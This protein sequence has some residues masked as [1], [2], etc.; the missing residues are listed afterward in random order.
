MSELGGSINH[1]HDKLGWYILPVGNCQANVHRQVPGCQ[2]GNGVRWTVFRGANGNPVGK[3]LS[4]IPSN[5][6]KWDSLSRW[7]DLQTDLSFQGWKLQ[8]DPQVATIPPHVSPGESIWGPW[9]C[10]SCWESP[11][12]AD[13]RGGLAVDSRSQRLKQNNS[14]KREIDRRWFYQN[15]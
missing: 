4:S 1:L 13:V 11:A 3:D 2:H 14:T 15:S 9:E 6:S 12:L 5:W 8:P 7:R 10:L